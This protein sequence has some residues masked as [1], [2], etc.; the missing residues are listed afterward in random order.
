[1]GIPKPYGGIRPGAN[2]VLSDQV[3]FAALLQVLRR[4]IQ[5]A[6]EWSSP[7]KDY[8]YRLK[9]EQSHAQWFE[10][11]FTRWKAFDHDSLARLNKEASTVG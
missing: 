7:S 10:S 3:V 5:P 6:L 2:L 1:V 9:K 11:Y 8:A 4:Q